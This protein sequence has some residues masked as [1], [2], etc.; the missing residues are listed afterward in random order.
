MI[1][2]EASRTEVRRTWINAHRMQPEET[3]KFTQGSKN[4]EGKG[5]NSLESEDDS[6]SISRENA[7]LLPREVGN[8]SPLGSLIIINLREK[9]ENKILGVDPRHL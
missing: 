1:V 9:V 3:T 5:D 2:T 4:P 8:G 7:P 6:S